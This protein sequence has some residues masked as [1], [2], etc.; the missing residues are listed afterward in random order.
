ML[1]GSPATFRRTILMRRST[2]HGFRGLQSIRSARCQRAAHRTRPTAWRPSVRTGQWRHRRRPSR[3]GSQCSPP[4]GLTCPMRATT[5]WWR[6]RRPHRPR[7]EAASGEPMT[8]RLPP[9]PTPYLKKIRRAPAVVHHK[10]R[11]R[12]LYIRGAGRLHTSLKAVLRV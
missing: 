10:G 6:A 5:S 8:S 12:N 3:L 1:P 2:G 11:C 7:I 9:F 4:P